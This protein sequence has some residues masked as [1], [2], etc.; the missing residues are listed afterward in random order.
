MIRYRA[1]LLA[2]LLM[3]G[4][5]RPREIIVHALVR[6]APGLKPGA[7]VEYRGID[8]G[9]VRSVGFTDAGV[10]LD[11]AIERRDA[12]IRSRDQVWITSEGTFETQVVDIIPGDSTAPLVA[13]GASLTAAPAD[14][15]LGMQEQVTRA[16]ADAVDR[17]VER[18]STGALRLRQVTAVQTATSSKPK[19]ARP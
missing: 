14:S 5:S 9:V 13:R 12:P 1:L 11:L 3:P 2:T 8:I 4:C 10:K 19:P 6:K 18:D 16:I 15:M 7:R 17:V